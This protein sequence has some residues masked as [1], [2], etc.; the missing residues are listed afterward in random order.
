MKDCPHYATITTTETS[1]GLVL[2]QKV[3]ARCGE[4][5]RVVRVEKSLSPREEVD[6]FVESMKGTAR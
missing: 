4:V 1:V 3:C 5:L 6:R 2:Q